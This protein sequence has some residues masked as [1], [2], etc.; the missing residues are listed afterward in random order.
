MT[1]EV[2]LLYHWNPSQYWNA[3]KYYQLE[4]IGEKSN[5]TLKISNNKHNQK[6]DIFI[7]LSIHK[8]QQPFTE[9]Q[10]SLN[11]IPKNHRRLIFDQYLIAA[12]DLPFTN[13]CINV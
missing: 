10:L 5:S 6:I 7:Y 2:K 11:K 12:V 3:A 13:D 1:I 8:S 9:F 4:N